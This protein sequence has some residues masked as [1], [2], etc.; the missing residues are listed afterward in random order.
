MPAVQLR[1]GSS[2]AATGDF[3]AAAD[4]YGAALAAAPGFVAARL[5]LGSV[6][7]RQ[8]RY[9]E[10][11]DRLAAGVGT[12][13]GAPALAQALALLLVACPDDAV[14]DPARGLELA[15]TAY[16]AKAGPLNGQTLAMALAATGRFEEAVRSQET[17]VTSLEAGKDLDAARARLALYQRGQPARAP[18]HADPAL[19]PPIVLPIL[20]PG[21]AGEAPPGPGG[22]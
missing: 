1:L 5:A 19:L 21:E 18:W 4:A 12:G 22:R 6:L 13:G 9:A 20:M 16:A 10:A 15:Q 3:T 11:R 7:I 17:I 8:G 2:A 14:R